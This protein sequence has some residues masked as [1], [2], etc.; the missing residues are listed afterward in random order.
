MLADWS[1]ASGTGRESLPGMV[2]IEA[3]VLAR[4]PDLATA[5]TGGL[6]SQAPKETYGRVQIVLLS[7]VALATGRLRPRHSGITGG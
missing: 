5:S 2:A 4:S 7:G 6:R 1:R 3:P